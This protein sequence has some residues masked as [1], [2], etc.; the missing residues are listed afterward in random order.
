MFSVVV[1]L[2]ELYSDNVIVV[3]ISATRWTGV[4][5]LVVAVGR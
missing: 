5:Q 4:E 2:L 3:Y 1:V